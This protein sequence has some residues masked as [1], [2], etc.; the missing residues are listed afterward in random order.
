ML[1]VDKSSFSTMLNYLIEEKIPFEFE[2]CGYSMKIISREGDYYTT[3]SSLP[4]NELWF[5]NKVKKHV[6]GNKIKF[7]KINREKI[8]YCQYSSLLKKTHINNVFEI[9]I[10]N[11]YWKTALNLG[12]IDESIYDEGLKM[13]KVTRLASLGSLAKNPIVIKNNGKT[14]KIMNTKEADSAFLWY[15]I[16]QHVGMIM[17]EIQQAL[18][19]EFIFMWVDGI[20]FKGNHNIK[21]VQ[22]I[23][24]GYDYSSKLRNL[25]I[26]P[27]IKEGRLYIYEKGQTKEEGRYF[28]LNN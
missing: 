17:K 19:S 12:F 13:D 24:K 14:E 28:P 18:K 26:K 16:A 10:K 6:L 4:M 9:D 5:V 25:N 27:S 11:A 20:Y 7:E 22:D 21:I 2:K 8:N 15:K 1:H 23:L 3:S